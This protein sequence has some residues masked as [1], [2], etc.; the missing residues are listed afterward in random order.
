M[1]LT[2]GFRIGFDRSVLLKPS[3][4]NQQSVN[5]DPEVVTEYLNAEIKAGRL[6][7][8]FQ[9]H[10]PGV[11]CSPIRII[12]KP[13]QPGKRRLI[14]NLSSLEGHSVNDQIPSHICSLSYS[15]VNQATQLLCKLGS[16]ALLAK[17]DLKCAYRMV[18]VHPL[19]QPLLGMEWEDSVLVDTCLPFGLR[20]APK[21]FLAV[22]DAISRALYLLGVENI[23]HYIDDFLFVG[24]PASEHCLI[25]LCTAIE[26][27]TKLGFPVAPF[28][29]SCPATVLTFLGIELDTVA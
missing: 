27:C 5:D 20:S 8:P 19:D 4:G 1:G 9:P 11:Y 6:N 17:L 16:G 2:E 28:K 7:G 23:L 10:L 13:N 15:S 3:K 22:A 26:T 12:H 18:P 14:V 29:V 21:I 24:P 25:T